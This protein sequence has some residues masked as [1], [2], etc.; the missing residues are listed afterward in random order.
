M[1]ERE[2]GLKMKMNVQQ[3]GNDKEEGI[4]VEIGHK[5]PH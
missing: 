3:T 5:G 4:M 1:F 2:L